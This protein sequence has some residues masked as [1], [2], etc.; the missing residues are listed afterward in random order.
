[1]QVLPFVTNQLNVTSQIQPK[2]TAKKKKQSETT[3]TCISEHTNNVNEFQS[4]G[5]S[6]GIQPSPQPSTLIV[7]EKLFSTKSFQIQQYPS[8]QM[9]GIHIKSRRYYGR[10]LSTL[11]DD[12]GNIMAVCIQTLEFGAKAFKIF[13]PK[14]LFPEQEAMLI[15]RQA[16]YPLCTV[17]HVPYH[18]GQE[19]FMEGGL[20]IPEY[21]IRSMKGISGRKLVMIKPDR[22]TPVATA[23]GHL[24]HIS[25]GYDPCLM[26]CFC[27]ISD[28]MV[29][30][31]HRGRGGSCCQ[32]VKKP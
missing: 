1:M 5:A 12:S 4:I 28:E 15:E 9:L 32:Y 19:V 3:S 17:K 25:A 16:M 20:L 2:R 14:R 27:A 30:D 13:I 24:L 22:D 7:K 6:A 26:I 8:F 21:E 11:Q 31:R 29:D 18:N 10:Q 23:E